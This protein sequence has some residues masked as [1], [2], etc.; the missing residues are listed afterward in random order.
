M[1]RTELFA[2]L[3]KS[4]AITLGFVERFILGS[5]SDEAVNLLLFPSSGAVGFFLKARFLSV[6]PTKFLIGA[7]DGIA[8]P[9]AVSSYRFL[10]PDKSRT[11]IRFAAC[12]IK[13]PIHS[14]DRIAITLHRKG[15][16]K[17][18]WRWQD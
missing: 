3:G 6:R 16:P 15:A 1:G 9:P 5:P 2:V 14:G 4:E 7:S 17:F 11:W 8:M 12:I 13:P 18:H 10:A